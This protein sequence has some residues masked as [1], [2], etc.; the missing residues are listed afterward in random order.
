MQLW[1]VEDLIVSL[2]GTD[3]LETQTVIAYPI[4]DDQDFIK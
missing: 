4:S 2:F 3:L 1:K